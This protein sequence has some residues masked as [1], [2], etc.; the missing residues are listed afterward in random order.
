MATDTEKIYTDSYKFNLIKKLIEPNK[1]TDTHKKISELLNIVNN[2]YLELPH[3]IIMRK[4]IPDLVEDLEDIV[5]FPIFFK[6]N[7]IAIVGG[8]SSGKSSFMNSILDYDG[9]EILPTSIEPTT[10]LATYITKGYSDNISTYNIFKN[11]SVIDIADF[12][13]LSHK[14]MS[15]L[16]FGI[17]HVI[18]YIVVQSENLLYNNILFVNHY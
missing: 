16:N 18:K 11:Q 10:A 13:L 2:E 8:F 3:D 7:T 14:A 12:N 17:K 4:E 15:Y 6:K 5:N 9:E 1:E